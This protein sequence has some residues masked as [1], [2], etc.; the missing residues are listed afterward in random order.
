MAVPSFTLVNGHKFPLV[1]LGTFT[2][3]DEKD[4]ETS[5]NEALKAGYRH[6]DTASAYFNEHIIGRVLKSWFDS[7]KLKREDL[8][9]TTKL[10]SAGVHPD[11]VEEDILKSLEQLQLDY[12]DL[13][14]IHFPVCVQAGGASKNDPSASVAQPTDHGAVWKKLEEQVELGRTRAI[15][16]SNFNKDQVSRLVKTAKIKPAANQ[17]ELHVY[18]QQPELVKYLKANGILPISYAS[19]GNPGINEFLVKQGRPPRPGSTELLE[20]PVIKK[21]AAKHGKSSGQVLLKFLVQNNIAVIP[22][23]V[24]PKRIQENINLFDFTL[25]VEDVKLL[26]GLDK[27]EQGRRYLMNFN[28]TVLDHPEYPFPKVQ[29]DI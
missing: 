25:D 6:I 24:T 20:D 16:V 12:L 15:G 7:G 2:V 10:A 26:T 18:L 13:Y 11:R 5:L 1:G 9:V 19:L 3:T 23:S 27:G 21:I 22:K 28:Q 14:L 29:R 17:V 8:F 4:L